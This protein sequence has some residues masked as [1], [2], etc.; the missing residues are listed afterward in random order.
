MTRSVVLV[1]GFGGSPLSMGW[2]AGELV[3]A[4]IP[5]A[6][7]TWRAADADW[8]RWTSAVKSA[9]ANMASEVVLVGQSAGAALCAAVAASV[10][11]VVGL[12]LANPLVCPMDE[13]SLDFI[14]ARFARGHRTLPVAPATFDDPDATDPDAA[15]A[16]LD[17]AGLLAVHGSLQAI[18]FGVVAAITSVMFAP[19]DDVLGPSH[20]DHLRADGFPRR[21]VPIAGG[22]LASLDSGRFELRDEILRLATG[23]H[24][25][26][27]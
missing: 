14:A 10:P 7:P 6:T 26:P 17:V 5:V 24:P 13:D 3:S 2:L 16:E 19:D 22:H 4:G 9:V 25:Q 21:Y 1:H 23:P 15:E 11:S 12:V 18:D 20:V 8:E 27:L